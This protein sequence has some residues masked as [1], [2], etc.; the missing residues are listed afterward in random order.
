[1]GQTVIA[2]NYFSQAVSSLDWSFQDRLLGVTVVNPAAVNEFYILGFQTN[3][4]PVKWS[5]DVS[6]TADGR[7]ARWQPGTNYVV[8]FG[9]ATESSGAE[10]YVYRVAA[11]SGIPNLTNR[12]DVG[13]PNRDVNALAWQPGTS[14]LTAGIYDRIYQFPYNFTNITTST[15]V[16]ATSATEVKRNA[17][18]WTANGA[19]LAVAFGGT[20]IRPLQIFQP[21]TG[22]LARV[23]TLEGE[24]LP[25]D[26]FSAVAWNPSGDRL[27]AAHTK[28]FTNDLQLYVVT[29]STLVGFTN[30]WSATLVRKALSLD[31]APFSEYLAVGLEKDGSLTNTEFQI[32]NYD[33]TSGDLILVYEEDMSANVNAL[34]WSRSGRYIA[35]GDDAHYVLI[36]QAPLAD[37]RVSKAAAPSAF[38]PGSNVTY[39]IAVTNAGPSSAKRVIVYDEAPTNATFLSAGPG[40]V[41]TNGRLTCEGGALSNGWTTNFSFTVKTSGSTVALTNRVRV[42]GSI[43]DNLT[44]NVFV[45]VTKQDSDG[46]GVADDVDNCPGVSNPDQAD[47]DGDGIGN[48]CDNCPLNANPL[49]IDTDGDGFGDACDLCPTNWS[50]FNVDSDGDGI[51]DGCDN[52]PA[53]YNPSQTNSDGD[54]YG[55]ACDN[56]PY[57]ANDDQADVDVDG[58]GNACDSDIDGDGLPNDWEILYGFN[59]YDANQP[60]WETYLDPDGDGY[61][62]IEEFVAATNPTNGASFFMVWAIS[63][64]TARRVVIPS[65]TGRTYAVQFTTDL[66]SGGWA[67]L[68]TNLLGSNGWTSAT[69]TSAAP[70]RAYRARVRMTNP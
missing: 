14:N 41:Y 26:D 50:L 16:Q 3:S 53:A 51:G 28:S 60:A 40:C 58:I 57:V 46:D 54:I 34:R 63:S 56:C 21:K 37:L 2:S 52:C 66:L 20:A 25:G 59:P 27:A 4:I 47:S 43:D 33:R 7:S 22:G 35:T 29:N 10:L 55:D 24:G 36:R 15:T 17:M 13:S 9:L 69:D 18:A 5:A 38:Y 68:T 19:Y 1:M 65:V 12:L 30:I 39:T 32:Y 62:N 64:D 8:A 23:G 48:A 45:L 70:V 61:P 11:T 44:N 31:W 67:N 49:Q 42:L 6:T